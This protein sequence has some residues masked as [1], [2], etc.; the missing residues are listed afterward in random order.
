MV[1]TP[2]YWFETTEKDRT[3]RVVFA[4]VAASRAAFTRLAFL[5]VT[6]TSAARPNLGGRQRASST[7]I[8]ICAMATQ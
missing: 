1:G 6:S 5:A 2:G 3:R 8:N 4:R 7:W